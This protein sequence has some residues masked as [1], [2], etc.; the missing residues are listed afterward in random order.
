MTTVYPLMRLGGQGQPLVLALANGIT[1]ETYVP[2]LRPLMRDYAVSCLLPRGMWLG[3]PVPERLGQWDEVADDLLA[4][5]AA[6]DLRD[7][8]MVGHSFG[9]VAAMIAAIREPERFRALVML[10]PTLLPP[11]VLDALHQMR[12][13]GTIGEGFHLAARAAKRQQT[14]ESV[15]A[16]YAYFKG[17]GAFR[18]WTEEATRAYVTH[19]LTADG[20]GGLRLAWPA[21]WETYYFKTGYLATWET[22]P[23]LH[24]VLPTLIVRGGTSDTYMPEPAARVRELLP[25]ATHV[26]IE[27]HG[28][29]FPQSAPE[30]AG[31]LVHDWL[32]SGG[33]GG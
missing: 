15:E 29:L 18:D 23:K 32:I 5:L 9:A 20:A 27:G 17:R 8:V 3:E 7:V 19:G 14:F 16:A 31:A 1:P 33:A 13:A 28:H 10:D 22:V 30:Q 24:G 11:H 2:M 26:E 6:H 4:G 12:E 21:E 25:E